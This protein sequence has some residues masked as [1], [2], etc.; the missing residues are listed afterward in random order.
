[1]LCS[2]CDARVFQNR[3]LV[4]IFLC[5]QILYCGPP[6]ENLG[7][8]GSDVAARGESPDPFFV[9]YAATLRQQPID[10]PR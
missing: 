8:D 9:Y 10:V 6:A 4:A 2:S 1:M 3:S 5:S 7:D